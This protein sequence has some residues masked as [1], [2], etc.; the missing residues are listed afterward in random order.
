M[1]KPGIKKIQ[2]PPSMIKV[3]RSSVSSSDDWVALIVKLEHPFSTNQSIGKLLAGERLGTSA[4]K[5]LAE[6]LKLSPMI[7]RLWQTLGVPRAVIQA[8]ERKPP[9]EATHAWLVGVADA[10][11]M[12]PA[13]H[14]FVT[15]LHSTVVSAR[16]RTLFIT[17][18]P[19]VSPTDGRMLPVVTERPPAMPPSTWEWLLSLPFGAV[20]FSTLGEGPPLPSTINNGDL[21]G[22]LYLTCW[23]SA[24]LDHVQP[25]PLQ[26]PAAS[27]PA[28][29]LLAADNEAVCK[30]EAWLAQVQDKMASMDKGRLLESRLI[31]QLYTA[32][33]KRAEEYGMDDADALA[34]GAA[35]VQALERE[36]HGG[37]IELPVHLHADFI[38]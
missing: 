19:C 29:A 32:W 12:L 15:G 16:L 24:I 23:S 2:L 3:A 31:G 6:K 22:D 10:T 5:E 11:D 27:R 30:G 21:D 7:V 33:D 1:R 35:F 17:R 28:T 36:K 38:K 18:S 26:R 8:Y 13:G 25:R 9:E 4:S 37:A 20:L 14:I 34:L